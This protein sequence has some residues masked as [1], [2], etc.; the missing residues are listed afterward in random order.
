MQLRQDRRTPGLDITELKG[1]PVV[2]S[3]KYLGV[4]VDDC[5]QFLPEI[6]SKNTKA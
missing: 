3:Y 5:L 4:I 2:N 1:I 6:E